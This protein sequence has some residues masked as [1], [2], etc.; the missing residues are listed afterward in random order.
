QAAQALDRPDW[1]AAAAR[2]ADFL[3]TRMRAPDGR[4]L[5]TWSGGAAPKL[6]AYLEDYSFLLDGLV[7]LYEATFATRWLQEALDLAAVMIDQ[8]WDEAEGGFFYTG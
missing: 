1:S 7:S 8:F 2:A 6:N 3:L 5:R 4:L